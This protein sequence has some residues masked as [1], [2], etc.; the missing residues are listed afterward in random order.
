M[1]FRSQMDAHLETGAM[2][3]HL[4]QNPM[5]EICRRPLRKFGWPVLLLLSIL[6]H[7]SHSQITYTNAFSNLKFAEPVFF[8]VYPGKPKTYVV[9]EQHKGHVLLVSE[10]GTTWKKDTLVTVAVHQGTEMG[11]LGIA[12]HPNFLTNRRYFLSYD[13]PKEFSNV[14]EERKVN[15]TFTKDAGTPAIEI[16]NITDKWVNHNGGQVFFGPK[17]GLLYFGTGDGGSMENDPD[18]NAQ[19]KEVLLGKML[20]IDVD[21]KEGSLNYGIPPTNPFATGGG[22]GEIFAYGFRNPF[23]WSFDP[24]TGD[25]WMGDVGWLTMEEVNIVTLGGNYG[26]KVM[27]GTGGTNSGSMILPVYAYGRTLGNA[28][29]GGVVF[30]G[31]PASKYYGTYFATDFYKTNLWTLTKGGANAATFTSIGPTPTAISGFGTDE[32]GRIYACGHSTGIIYLLESADLQ[33]KATVSTFADENKMRYRQVFQMTAGA[34]LGVNAFA[35]AAQ[36]DIYS[37]QG[38]HLGSATKEN[39]QLPI[40]LRPGVYLLKSDRSNQIPNLLVVR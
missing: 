16:F 10:S 5:T 1:S 7:I 22:R 18:A 32:T 15:E 37:L 13:P 20:R 9:L 34:R 29:I 8:G 26:W 11:L 31:D 2:E 25:I 30:R 40:A 36:L 21:K 35:D 23:K 39:A 24:L 38:E 28:V 17:D 27:E 14:L 6:S 4:P 12:F 3:I 33:G 19:N